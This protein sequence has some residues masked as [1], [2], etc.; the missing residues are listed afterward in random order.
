MES[1]IERTDET[2]VQVALTGKRE[3]FAELYSRHFDAVYDFLYR[4][5]RDRDEAADVTQETFLKAMEALPKLRRGA[6]FKGWLFSIARNTA[7]NRLER[8]TRQANWPGGADDDDSPPFEQMDT[9]RLANPEAALADKE[10]AS[11]VWEAASSLDRKQY[12]LLDLHL[13]QGLDSGEIAEAIGVTKGN[14]Y[15]ML[16]RLKNA[17]EESVVALLLARKGRRDCPELDHLLQG[18]AWGQLTSGARKIVDDHLSRCPRCQETRKKLVSPVEIF[19]AFAAVPAPLGLRDGIWQSL[20]HAWLAGG[21]APW[22]GGSGSGS[23]DSGASGRGDSGDS[24]AGNSDG[25]GTGDSGSSDLGNSHGTSPAD[26]GG[27]GSPYRVGARPARFGHFFR[28]LGPA[29]AK[30]MA[31]LAGSAVVAG[32]G[33]WI[34]LGVVGGQGGTASPTPFVAII[35]NSPT[36]TV[37]ATVVT[38]APTLP[39]VSPSPPKD[40]LISAPGSPEI[41]VTSTAESIPTSTPEPPGTYTPQ[42]PTATERPPDTAPTSTTAPPAPTS[43]LVPPTPFTKTPDTSTPTPTS[44]STPPLPTVTPTWT[45]TLPPTPTFTPTPSPTWTK[46]PERKPYLFV[47]VSS[48]QLD[49]GVSVSRFTIENKGGGLLQWSLASNDFWL[50]ANPVGGSLPAGGVDVVRVNVSRA[51]LKPGTYVGSLSISSN[52]GGAAVQ[53]IL[54]N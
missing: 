18:I 20:S 16:S 37:T 29:A 54:F 53:V 52:G 2:L 48:L 40:K 25:S 1:A 5:V 46:V 6:S 34:G 31:L 8:A 30:K 32:A 17:L 27:A 44:T 41:P 13:R 50:F 3:A 47:P 12:A 49:Q 7:L 39:P 14:A 26:S 11:L 23:A 9:D 38:A 24:S 19:G 4:M 22:G 21:Q 35:A 43:I 36:A 45:P 42:P 28:P 51:G 15:T 33:L 10:L